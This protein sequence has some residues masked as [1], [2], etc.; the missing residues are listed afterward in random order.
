MADLFKD[1]E[2]GSAGRI[3]NELEVLRTQGQDSLSKIAQVQ[4]NVLLRFERG[5]TEINFKRQKSFKAV[6]VD[7]AVKFLISDFVDLDQAQTSAT[8][9]IDSKSAT[10]KEK[11]R[12]A[13]VPVKKLS[14]YNDVGTV[15]QF[16][17]LYRVFTNDGQVPTGTFEIELQQPT[18]LSLIVFDTVISPSQ[19]AVSVSVSPN[20]VRYTTAQAVARNGYRVNSW[21]PQE[22]VKFI[23][24]RI[25][26]SHP[27]MLS[28][29]SYTFG[30]TDLNVF[31]V[32]FFLASELTTAPLSLPVKTPRVKFVSY[33]DDPRLTYFL[34]F[35]SQ[36]YF[37]VMP[38]DL[39]TIP[40]LTSV[41]RRQLTA[42]SDSWLRDEDVIYQFPIDLYANTLR[43]EPV[44]GGVPVEILH[45]ANYPELTYYSGTVDVD[46]DTNK[47]VRWKTGDKF[48]GLVA[49]RKILIDGIPKIISSVLSEE[50]LTVF[51][52]PSSK[53]GVEYMV[54][55]YGGR[56]FGCLHPTSRRMS[57]QPL[58]PWG[59]GSPPSYLV[60]YLA[61]PAVEVS[62][63][64]QLFT[65]DK[66]S[67][68][69]FEG[70]HLEYVYE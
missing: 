61:G 20:G 58:I 48:G 65:T 26:P 49:G 5:L 33:N 12:S 14:F 34:S 60:S 17:D 18:L 29:N 39:V 21:V 2:S 15:E 45:H 30:L 11:S 70:A 24:I 7:T 3:V 38:G 9:R 19:P 46:T 47:T 52:P 6:N 56:Q 37:Q 53:N 10:L 25:T 68:P 43:V 23:R 22:S 67:S 63:K 64:A 54:G 66:S 4:Q 36:P 69:V 57:M 50:A 40:G 35:N 31:S 1:G 13:Y 42:G 55:D 44:S 59:S 8:V 32:E 27:D 62:L 41:R 28:G 51:N 16:G